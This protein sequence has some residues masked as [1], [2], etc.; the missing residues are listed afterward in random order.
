MQCH[1]SVFCA[2]EVAAKNAADIQQAALERLSAASG[3]VKRTEYIDLE[4]DKAE[5]VD[6]PTVVPGTAKDVTF[7][8]P[9]PPETVK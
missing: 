7:G 3:P 2:I 5:Q 4:R 6:M 9:V 1:A 8:A